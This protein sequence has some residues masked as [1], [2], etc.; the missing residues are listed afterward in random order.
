MIGAILIA[1]LSLHALPVLEL[2]P[3]VN[4]VSVL[5]ANKR[6]TALRSVD[7]SLDGEVGGLRIRGTS[8]VDVPAGGKGKL[9]ID[10]EVRRAP[11]ESFELPLALRDG[12]GQIWKLKALVK[13]LPPRS[14]ELFPNFPNPFNPSTTIAFSIPSYTR[15]RLFIYNTLGQKVKT[16]VDGPK[17]PGLYEIQWDG[18][19]DEGRE[20]SSG[21]Y[22]YRLEAGDFVATGKMLLLR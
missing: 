1:G 20:V 9:K 18:R 8:P 21:L 11:G 22:F 4:Q 5:I 16:L 7:A 19:D 14:Y 15:C 3:G 6:S 10:L 13:V 12:T 17:E 2:E